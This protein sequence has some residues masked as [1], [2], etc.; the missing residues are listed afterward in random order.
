MATGPQAA[1]SPAPS[2]APN[3][4]PTLPAAY[5]QY[6]FGPSLSA[7]DIAS[8]QAGSKYA[9]RAA[10]QTNAAS[11]VHSMVGP[12]GTSAGMRE[13]RAQYMSSKLRT[14]R[15]LLAVGDRAGAMFA[16]GEAIH[17]LMDATSPYHTDAS[18]QPRMWDSRDLGGSAKHGILEFKTRPSTVDL[19]RNKALLEAAY[20]K[21][22]QKPQ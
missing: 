1:P 13:A 19:A 22:E 5:T 18:G 3:A 6:A 4:P 21:L 17:P 10:M 15:A 2:A 20:R 8:I 12:G 11:Y 16:F 9:D 7:A 14:A